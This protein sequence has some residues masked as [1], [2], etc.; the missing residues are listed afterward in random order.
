MSPRRQVRIAG[1]LSAPRPPASSESPA[2]PPPLPR[3]AAFS[4][5]HKY[6]KNNSFITD[7]H[8][9]PSWFAF[10]S[11][12][13]SLFCVLGILSLKLHK[14]VTPHRR[15][16][17]RSTR[18]QNFAMIF[19]FLTV[20]LRLSPAAGARVTRQPRPTD[21][22]APARHSGRPPPPDPDF[23]FERWLVTA[24]A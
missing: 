2:G 18:M 23:Q 17:G 4:N 9:E 12:C 19:R 15:R 6:H 14:S 16:A 3:S 20:L 10:Y 5:I 24:W 8:G 22:A 1:S 7:R 21:S 11:L 13:C